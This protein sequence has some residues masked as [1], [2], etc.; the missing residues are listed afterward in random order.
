MKSQLLLSLIPVLVPLFIAA[1]KLAV[2]KVPKPLLPILAPILGGLADAG[3]A[4][5]AGSAANPMLG[6]ALGAAGVGVREIVDQV[7]GGNAARAMGVLLCV[8]VLSGCATTAPTPFS[9]DKPVIQLDY[10][11]FFL[12]YTDAGKAYAVARYI[13]SQECATKLRT[14]E[15]CDVLTKADDR[16]Q[17]ADQ[18]IRKSIA[19]P[20]YP[21]DW[22]K[23]QEFLGQVMGAL[24]KIGVKGAAAGVVP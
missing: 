7:R 20:R 23:V 16:I 15:Q 17:L 1:L 18:A 14:P 22:T 2:P 6:A 13:V 10:A 12:T 4:Y 19:D 9:A 5:A 21:V 11:A 3:I 8:G 24:V